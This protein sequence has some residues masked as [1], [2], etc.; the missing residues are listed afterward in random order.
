M[1]TEV[2][3]RQDCCT[4]PVNIAKDF[5]RCKLRMRGNSLTS[6]PSNLHPQAPIRPD[7]LESW[8][9]HSAPSRSAT[10][11]NRILT[12]DIEQYGPERET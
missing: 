3:L 1:D 10:S 11:A 9:F 2:S 7:E 5:N 4:V 6:W 12:S 8:A